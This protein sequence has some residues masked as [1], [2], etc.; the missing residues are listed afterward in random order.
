MPDLCRCMASPFANHIFIKRW[1]VVSNNVEIELL[2]IFQRMQLHSQN[3]NT[4]ALSN[5][6]KNIQQLNDP[7]FSTQY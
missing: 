5:K 2:H 6:L 4:H 7:I 3:K 1:K